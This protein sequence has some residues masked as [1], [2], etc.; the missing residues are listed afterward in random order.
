MRESERGSGGE[1]RAVSGVVREPTV[2]KVTMG[3]AKGLCLAPV[4]EFADGHERGAE[5]GPGVAMGLHTQP[6]SRMTLGAGDA[7]RDGMRGAASQDGAGGGAGGSRDLSAPDAGPGA[8]AQFE[9]SFSARHP[10]SRQSLCSPKNSAEHRDGPGRA[11]ERAQPRCPG[12]ARPPAAAA[13]W[14]GSR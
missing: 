7:V 13:L 3:I 10:P 5:R 12:G 6:G 2:R 9:S 14:S 8:A 11:G 4:K 1:Y